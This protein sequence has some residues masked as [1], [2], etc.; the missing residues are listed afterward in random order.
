MVEG[1]IILS[2]GDIV[3]PLALL[4]LPLTGAL[5]AFFTSIRERWLM[6]VAC[7]LALGFWIRFLFGDDSDY[8]DIGK[9]GAQVLGGIFASIFV[10]FFG[11]GVAIGRIARMRRATRR[12]TV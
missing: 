4:V 2:L 3:G 7:L 1:G 11:G 6:A 12:P 5:L 9:S 8:Y 10:V